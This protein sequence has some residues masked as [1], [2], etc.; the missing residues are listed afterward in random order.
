MTKHTTEEIRMLNELFLALF[1][2]A[3]FAFF[4]SL[5]NSPY[6]WFSLAGAGLGLAI[7]VYCW[8]GTKYV[9]F[10]SALLVFTLLF[11]IVYNWGALFRLH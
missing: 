2:V 1:I 5:L 4:L 8:S 3:D 6:P 9:L 10:N 7:I 11:S